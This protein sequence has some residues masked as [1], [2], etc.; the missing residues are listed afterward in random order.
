MSD[1]FLNVIFKSSIPSD[2]MS[3]WLVNQENCVAFTV[4]VF[5]NILCKLS[6]FFIYIFK[7]I[8]LIINV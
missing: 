3:A 1:Q 5:R 2:F 7:A 6:H 4:I 8:L